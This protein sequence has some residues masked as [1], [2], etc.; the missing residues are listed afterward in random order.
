MT[1]VKYRALLGKRFKDLND[2]IYQNASER[3]F[4]AMEVASFL[5]NA[6]APEDDILVGMMLAADLAQ[7]TGLS[8]ELN[9]RVLRIAEARATDTALST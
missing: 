6:V 8:D 5:H 4:Y 3:Y 2:L 9:A 1:N 7:W